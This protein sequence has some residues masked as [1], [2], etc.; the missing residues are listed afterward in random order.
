MDAERLADVFARTLLA[1]GARAV[2]GL[3]GGGNNLEVVGAVQEVGLPFVLTH[4]E[5]AA[6]VMAAVHADLTGAPSAVV[7]TRGPG[8]ASAINGAA[9]ALLD[10][11]AILVLTDSVPAQ[12]RSRISHQFLDQRAMFQPVTKASFELGGLEPERTMA[13]AL[14]LATRHPRGPVHLDFDPSS[15]DPAEVAPPYE[16]VGEA[17][18]DQLEAARDLLAR[19]RHPVVLLGIG[20]RDVVTPVRQL[21]AG[22]HVP[23]LMTYR[24]KGVVPDSWANCAGVL[25]GATVESAVLAR[26]DAILTIGLDAVELIPSSWPY[27]AP[28]VS[29]SSWED[30]TTYLTRAVDVIGDLEQ[31]V[32][33][34][35]GSLTSDWPAGSGQQL[36]QRGIALLLEQEDQASTI[37]PQQLVRRVRALAP[38]AT[39]ATVDAGAHM[40]AV[41]PLWE[42]ENRDEV[43]VS[44][45]L[46]TMGFALPAAIAAALAR[47]GRRIVC[48]V[49]DGGLG[50]VL[51]EL[52]TLVRLDLPVSVIV[53][54]DSRLSL[55]AVKQQSERHG[56]ENAVAYRDIA[57]DRVAEGFGI[58]ARAVSDVAELD[59]A[60]TAMLATPGPSLL[61]ARVDPGCYPGVLDAIRGAR[62]RV[63]SE[64]LAS[65]VSAQPVVA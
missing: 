32:A 4:S 14:A 10:R 7:V 48:F 61:D 2:F 41:L 25:T 33:E 60:I 3:P 56:G 36:R 43:I 53:F 42:T 29:I 58:P 34:M 63:T 22:S 8:A 5:T 21:L 50:M 18:Q 44:S 16:V 17:P 46:A 40:L 15:A 54:N 62:H 6:A 65:A 55:I 39:I 57:F 51:A 26:A 38:A 19:A 20:A 49:G 64:S 12:E 30:R 27:T 35:F 52:E 31:L 28:V 11:Q 13:Q 1:S 23:V 37:S 45:G 9:Q 24:A 59:A 47:P